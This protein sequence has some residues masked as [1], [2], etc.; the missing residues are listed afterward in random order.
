MVFD[1][2]NVSYAF[3]L[4]HT[5]VALAQHQKRHE[6]GRSRHVC[7]ICGRSYAE[8][9]GYIHHMRKEHWNVKPH[10]CTYC[11]QTYVLR[12]ELLKHIQTHTKT[13]PYKCPL[14]DKHFPYTSSRSRHV[15]EVHQK[16]TSRGLGKKFLKDFKVPEKKTGN[17]ETSGKL[18]HTHENKDDLLLTA[19]NSSPSAIDDIGT[20]EL[21][22]LEHLMIHHDFEKSPDYSLWTPQ[23]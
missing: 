4:L 19:D 8:K 23:Y 11:P 13:K 18:S 3:S 2:P 20:E 16:Q 6:E 9:K 15:R 12:S 1:C 7:E 21:K 22:P 10:H 5:Q 14:C 17:A